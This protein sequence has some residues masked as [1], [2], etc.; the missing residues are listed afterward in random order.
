MLH[1]LYLSHQLKFSYHILMTDGQKIFK[2]IICLYCTLYLYWKNVVDLVLKIGFVINSN[3]YTFIYIQLNFLIS[4]RLRW[5][6]QICQ[7]TI[8]Y[9]L[10]DFIIQ[11]SFVFVN[12][13]IWIQVTIHLSIFCEVNVWKNMFQNN[14]MYLSLINLCK[15]VDNKKCLYK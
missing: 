9:R 3:M 12:K 6:K 2:Y 10:S 15:N 4:F 5:L 1:L 8:S 7:G 11:C 14:Y 13:F